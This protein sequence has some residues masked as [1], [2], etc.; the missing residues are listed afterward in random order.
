ML[1][2]RVG[3]T[4]RFRNLPHK[5][6]TKMV[7]AER[8]VIEMT[9]RQTRDLAPETSFERSGLEARCILGLVVGS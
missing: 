3:G 9:G 7:A 2:H 5:M 4:Q 6:A 1:D 8:G